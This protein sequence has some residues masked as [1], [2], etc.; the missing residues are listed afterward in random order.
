MIKRNVLFLLIFLTIICGGVL[1]FLRL[2][3]LNG[4]SQTDSAVLETQIDSTLFTFESKTNKVKLLSIDQSHLRN[5]LE[6][7]KLLPFN[8]VRFSQQ[9][10]QDKNRVQTPISLGDIK[11]IHIQI[12]DLSDDLPPVATHIFTQQIQNKDAVQYHYGQVSNSYTEITIPLY[13]D[14]ELIKNIRQSPDNIYSLR[15]LSDL[16]LNFKNPQLTAGVDPFGDLF[17]EI[18]AEDQPFLYIQLN[19]QQSMNIMDSLHL[20]LTQLKGVVLPQVYAA[21]CSAGSASCGSLNSQQTCQGG[22]Y[23]GTTCFDSTDCNGSPCQNSTPTCTY[24][25]APAACVLYYEDTGTGGTVPTGCVNNC[26]CGQGTC[27]YSGSTCTPIWTACTAACGT[28]TQTSTNCGNKTRQCN[29]QPCGNVCGDGTCGGT[30]SCSTCA[31]DCG[32]CSG[33]FCGNGSC[34]AGESCSNCSADCGGCTCTPS[35]VPKCGQTSC[36]STCSNSDTIAPVAPTGQVPTNGGSASLNGSNQITVSWDPVAGTLMSYDVEVYPTGTPAGQECTAT[37]THCSLGQITTSYTFTISGSIGQSYT[38]RI[39]AK[40]TACS[41]GGVTGAWSTPITFTIQGSISGNIYFDANNTAALSGGL[42]QL[43]GAPGQDPGAGSTITANTGSNTSGTITGSSYTIPNVPYNVNTL[44]TLGPDLSQWTCSC[45]AGCTYSGLSSPRSGVNFYLTNV[46]SAWWQTSNGLLYAGNSSGNALVSKIPAT[47]SGASCTPA[48]STNDSAN[49]AN[50]F[51]Y[52]VTGGGAIDTTDDVST[53]LSYLNPN[54]TSEHFSGGN[55]SGAH[56]NYAYFSQ[57]YS[58]GQNPTVDFTG[59]KPTTPTN[60]RAFYGSGNIDINTPWL[61][62]SN[63]K[64]IIFVDG[65]VT[66]HSQ[67]TVTPGGFLAIISTGNITFAND[68]GSSDPTSTTAVVAGVFISDQQIVIEGGRS[69]GDLKFIGEG[70]FIGWNGFNFGRTYASVNTNN[71]SPTEYFRF[72]P[73]FMVN[74]PERMTRPIY[75]WQET[76]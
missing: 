41:A 38:W 44:V 66:I 74:V 1:F 60:G 35:C 56:E 48:V 4:N 53:S 3:H 8:E 72:R 29:T 39:R 70:S 65:S 22:I 58:M 16:Y 12:Y 45:P 6:K 11:R 42:C 31:A 15:I 67:I 2:K 46:K 52:A 49:T 25:T 14:S 9:Y 37:D 33:N 10:N 76:N 23:N 40:N 59:T 43:A 64:M 34:N 50:S 57:L 68:L 47:C 21:S 63:E 71:T 30:E 7:A 54:G 24:N 51:G 20:L 69:G 55:I 26:A 75:V 19:N 36:G 13:V 62:G 17:N 32:S 18:T 28:G 27:T 61:I 73:D 5:L